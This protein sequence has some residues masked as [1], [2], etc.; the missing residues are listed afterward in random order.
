V[1]VE[2]NERIYGL[3]ASDSKGNVAAFL[4]ALENYG[5]TTGLAVLLYTD[6]EYAFKGMKK[7]VASDL[8][9]SISPKDI[10]SIDGNGLVIG[11]GC[12]G[13][14]EL[15]VLIETAS[16]H[17]ANPSTIGAI[18]QGFRLID[19]LRTWLKEMNDEF[20]GSP[21][22]NI[23]GIQGGFVTQGKGK[24]A[25][26]EFVGNQIANMA[27]MKIEVRAIPGL[28]AKDLV[29]RMQ[30]FAE[31]VG[32][33]IESNVLY[34]L[35][36]FST[37]RECTK[38]LQKACE[39]T[40]ENVDYLDPSTFGYLDLAMLQEVYENA[41]LYSFG[42]GEPGVNHKANEYIP[43]QNLEQGERVYETF[44]RNVLG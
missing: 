37:P 10:L 12:R 21:T 39:D 19:E 28:R 36:S 32:V 3:G 42:I 24:N 6:E 44:L 27:K 2:K 9:K 43:T 33:K 22:L 7:F 15:D 8:A 38:A 1:P 29:E 41:N 14:I 30:A 17:S 13:L 26:I 23:G 31:E 35:A 25:E 11:R 16:G 20:L 40:L 5:P 18:D 34:D 4:K